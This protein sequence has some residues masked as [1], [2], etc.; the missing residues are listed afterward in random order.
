[1]ITMLSNSLIQQ[2]NAN[3]LTCHINMKVVSEDSSCSMVGRGARAA[4]AEV[5]TGSVCDSKAAQK[6]VYTEDC[7]PYLINVELIT[8][9]HMSKG[10]KSS[11]CIFCWCCAS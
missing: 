8:I 6:K 2:H 11:T 1:M 9:Y 4:C 10:I 7:F 5:S 3:R